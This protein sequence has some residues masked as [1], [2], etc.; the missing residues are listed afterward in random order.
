MAY[1]IPIWTPPS[2]PVAGAADSFPEI[3]RAHV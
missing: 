2:L 3:G 1:A